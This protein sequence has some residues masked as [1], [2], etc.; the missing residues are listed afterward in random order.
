MANSDF[1]TFSVWNYESGKDSVLEV[2]KE[3]YLNCNISNPIQEYKDGNTKVKL[4]RAGP[5]YF[6]SGAKGHCEKGQ[7]V[8]VVVLS[9]RRRYTGISPAP[10]PSPVE[11]DAP[12][13]APTSSASRLGG[14]LVV[15]FG[16]LLLR[17]LF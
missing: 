10:A 13:V 1:Q 5:Y 2:S 4:N 15:A 9:P 12:A 14:C 3:D 11:F 7:K 16:L 6:I 8:L 17:G